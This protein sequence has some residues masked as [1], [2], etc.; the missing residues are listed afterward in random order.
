AEETENYTGAEI[1]TV[2]RKAYELA[3][4]DDREG[5]VLTADIISEA[6]IRC[7]PST[8][9]VQFMTMLAIEECDDKDLLPEKYKGL[10]DKKNLEDR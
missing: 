1:E 4:E 6:I 10:L 2:V 8:Q 9:Q 3:N 5:T 7:R